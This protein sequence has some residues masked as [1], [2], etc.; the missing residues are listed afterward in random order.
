MRNC[1]ISLPALQGHDLAM[2]CFAIQLAAADRMKLTILASAAQKDV[3]RFCVPA[4]RIIPQNANRVLRTYFWQLWDYV[5]F[6]GQQP[7]LFFS[8]QL[9]MGLRPDFFWEDLERLHHVFLLSS[10]AA[11]PVSLRPPL[12]A[13]VGLDIRA[14]LSPHYYAELIWHLIGPDGPFA[15]QKI[16]LISSTGLAA[17]LDDLYN[18]LPQG[19]IRHI[20]PHTPHQLADLDVSSVITA[21]LPAAFIWAL[22]GKKVIFTGGGAAN[23][24]L[25][26]ALQGKLI[27][28]PDTRPDVIA[29]QLQ[30]VDVMK[31]KAT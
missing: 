5:I 16:T 8:P 26:P 31:N 23:L 17:L 9:A 1:L 2:I 13:G 20:T 14:G 29:A 19:Q 7:K 21:D 22:A 6:A 28:C 30:Q 15:G 18:R 25:L 27:H 24:A 11:F 12:S 3:I 10:S 4:A